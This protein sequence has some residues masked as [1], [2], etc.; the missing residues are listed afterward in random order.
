MITIVKYKIVLG[1]KISIYNCVG[2]GLKMS[3]Y[4]ICAECDKTFILPITTRKAQ[5][6]GDIQQLFC[7]YC[8]SPNVY[9]IQKKQYIKERKKYE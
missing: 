7:V 1:L 8:R 5:S 3:K 4:Y 6:R 2:I 9:S